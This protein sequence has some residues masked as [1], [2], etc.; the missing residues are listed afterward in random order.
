MSGLPDFRTCAFCEYFGGGGEGAVRWAI[1][2]DK[3]IGGDCLNRHA[4]RSET[5]QKNS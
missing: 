5:N 2:N 3:D 4:D 1:R